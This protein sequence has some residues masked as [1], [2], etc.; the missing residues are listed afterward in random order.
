MK[1]TFKDTWVCYDCG[2]ISRRRFTPEPL[3]YGFT[4]TI[5]QKCG[6]KY[7]GGFTAR[8][9]VEKR[10]WKNL[11]GLISRDEFIEINTLREYTQDL[12][13]GRAGLIQKAKERY[14]QIRHHK[15]QH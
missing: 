1:G 14:E 10:C 13:T 7:I 12:F 11:F 2:F 15:H 3:C 5:C 8:Y 4:P 6:G 9:Y